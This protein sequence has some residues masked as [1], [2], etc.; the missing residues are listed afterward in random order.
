M[1]ALQEKMAKEFETVGFF[2]SDH[3]LNQYHDIFK[4]FN[5]HSYKHINEDKDINEG[6]IAAT[7]LKVQEKKTQKGTS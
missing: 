6:S 2:I 7:I 5:I 4:E 1:S 3:P